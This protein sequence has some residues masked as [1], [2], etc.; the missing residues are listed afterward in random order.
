V[1]HATILVLF[2]ATACLAGAQQASIDAQKLEQIRKMSP[3]ERAKLKARLEE[4]KKLSPSERERLDQNLKKIRTMPA[5][6]V[7]KA[8][9]RAAKLTEK[10]H[11]EFVELA[12]DF[13]K[14]ERRR[15]YHEGFPRGL[16]FQ[17]LKRDKP[18]KLEEIRAMEPGP[19]SPRVDAFI[20]LSHDFRVLTLAK[21][22]EHARRHRCISAEDV[23]AM[24]DLPPNEYWIRW[25]EVT[26]NCGRKAIP[27]PVPPRP[28]D[29]PK[30]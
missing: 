27:G 11:K 14:W 9:E 3:E 5:E 17:W 21:T 7:K 19:G 18:G 1:R 10:D 6:E 16:F 23:Q 28:L 12:S 29:P 8:T 25:S 26:R 24:R 2:F 15:G 22:E 20:H 30:K 4:I 13:F